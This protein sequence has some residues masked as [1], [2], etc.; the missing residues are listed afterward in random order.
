MTNFALGLRDCLHFKLKGN[1][2]DIA[3]WGHEF[4]RYGLLRVDALTMAH[5]SSHSALSA[6]IS[7]EFPERVTAKQPTE[8]LMKLVA[9]IIPF[10]AS[11]PFYDSFR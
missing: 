6:E 8:D 5:L 7:Q 1:A 2:T 4:V 9:E 10:G 11:H 3:P